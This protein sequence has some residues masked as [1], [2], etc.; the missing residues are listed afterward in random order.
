MEEIAGKHVLNLKDRE[1]LTVT[2]IRHVINYDEGEIILET[3]MGTLN[4]KGDK[5]N[6]LNLDL[7]KGD[8]SVSGH[9]TGFNY[10]ENTGE[11]RGKLRRQGILRRILK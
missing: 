8:L 6:I 10:S 3:D 4:L 1:Y 5:L 9:F 7:K 11:G 2:G